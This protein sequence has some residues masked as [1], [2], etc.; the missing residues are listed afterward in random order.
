MASEKEFTVNR[1]T[2]DRRCTYSTV[3]IYAEYL[4]IQFAYP[5]PLHIHT[6]RTSEHINIYSMHTYSSCAHIRIFAWECDCSKVG[7]ESLSSPHQLCSEFTQQL[8]AEADS[9]SARKT[10][11]GTDDN[12]EHVDD[13]LGAA[14]RSRHKAWLRYY[15]LFFL[16]YLSLLN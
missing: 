13:S 14:P 9:D 7:S 6:T 3:C 1:E 15:I 10:A 16:K 2:S 4:L 11:D 5:L 12:N 8:Y